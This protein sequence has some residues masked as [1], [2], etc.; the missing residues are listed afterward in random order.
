MIKRASLLVMAIGI[1]VA[2]VA[3]GRASQADIN[4][5]LGITPTPTLTAG[6]QAATAKAIAA[7]ATQEA[8]GGSPGSIVA[9]DP[10]QGSIAFNTQCAGCHQV[11]GGG[12]AADITAKGS[13]G[14]KVTYAQLKALI[15]TGQ[16][17]NPPGAFT[18]L[19]ISDQ[20]I[21]DIYAYLHQSASP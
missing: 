10:N 12:S 19:E 15:R 20:A 4:R 7:L 1:A 14:A 8:A 13:A 9:G 17:H 3:C 11:G 16:G 6:Q 5:A 2:A 21:A 18:E